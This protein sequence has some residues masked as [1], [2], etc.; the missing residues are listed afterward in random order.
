M[1]TGWAPKD[2]KKENWGKVG[3]VRIWEK[4]GKKRDWYEEEWPPEKVIIL[5]EAEYKKLK[6]KG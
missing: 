2:W 5:T 4:K 3:A 6:N 1:V